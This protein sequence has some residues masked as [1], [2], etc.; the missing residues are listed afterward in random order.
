M[1]R[2]ARA[3]GL[4]VVLTLAGACARGAT[5]GQ[6]PLL[7]PA[8]APLPAPAPG[9]LGAEAAA[10][11]ASAAAVLAL[12]ARGDPRADTLLDREADFI[13]TGIL[14]TT[15]PRLAG[16]TGSG[17]ATLE[18]ATTSVAGAIA[19]VVAGYRFEGRTPELAA[20]A[21][22]TFVLER[23][24]AGWRIRHVHSSMVEGW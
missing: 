12:E 14:V 20:R 22:G 17:D 11:R 24:R 1:R 21:R 13:M 2:S 5:S 18:T 3:S 19:W 10:A 7:A 6:P 4:A 23:Q 8:P 16:L 9:P 15:R